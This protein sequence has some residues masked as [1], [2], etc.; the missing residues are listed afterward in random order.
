LFKVSLKDN[1][2]HGNHLI[3]YFLIEKEILS[4]A[5]M[6]I[7]WINGISI[8]YYLLTDKIFFLLLFVYIRIALFLL[9]LVSFIDSGFEVDVTPWIAFRNSFFLGNKVSN[10]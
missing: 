1:G 6:I 10:R 8:I 7:G 5:K 9:L 2:T 3:V 4:A